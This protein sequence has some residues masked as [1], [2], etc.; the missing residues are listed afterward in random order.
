MV[1]SFSRSLFGDKIIC[2]YRQADTRSR[3]YLLI[4]RT[5]YVKNHVEKLYYEINIRSPHN[6][7]VL[8]VK[9]PIYIVNLTVIG[10]KKVCPLP[11]GFHNL[12]S[13]ERLDFSKKK[14]DGFSTLEIKLPN[15]LK[16]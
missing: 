16:G 6:F 7:D 2:F 15:S 14:L 9:L 5:N 4:L 13:M 3:F 8:E 12:F 10:L 11:Q 1:C